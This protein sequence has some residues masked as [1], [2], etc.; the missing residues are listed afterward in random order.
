MLGRRHWWEIL[1]PWLHPYSDWKVRGRGKKDGKGLRPAWDAEA[2]PPFLESLGR[3]GTQDLRA[4]AKDWHGEDRKYK[5]E[6]VL[7]SRALDVATKAADKAEETAGKALDKYEE[8]NGHR[9]WK[10]SSRPGW[11]LALL[12]LLEVP[13]NAASFRGVSDNELV[14][15]VLA[16]SLGVILAL[17]AHYF[18]RQLRA[19]L[20]LSH[21]AV[22]LILPCA[23]IAGGAYIRA[24]Y[25]AMKAASV[26]APAF[27]A[28]LGFFITFNIL[29]YTVATLASYWQH[30]PFGSEVTQTQHQLRKACEKR[31]KA[32]AALEEAIVQRQKKFLEKQEHAAWIEQEVGRLRDVYWTANLEK[33]TDSADVHATHYPKAYD[34]QVEVKMPDELRALSWDNTAAAIHT[35]VVTQPSVARV[36]IPLTQTWS[37][38]TQDRLKRAEK[39]EEVAQ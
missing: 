34:R 25:V 4:L 16:L 20:N 17:V 10:A 37:A 1:M 3:A 31:D 27:G 18:G 30:I 38:N 22:F 15:W 33:R 19:K 2:L 5:T 11:W 24:H 14:A 28:T 6:F 12:C 26:A 7:A 29:F 13:F 23:L 32:D 9:L 8:A 21:L 35:Q 39:T 36:Q